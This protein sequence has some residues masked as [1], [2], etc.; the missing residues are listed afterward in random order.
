MHAIDEL[1]AKDSDPMIG[2]IQRQLRFVEEWTREGQRPEQ[3][4][5]D[6]LNFGLMASRAVD[7]TNQDLANQLYELSSYLKFW[8]PPGGWPKTEA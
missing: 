6:R 8:P 1:A 7:D 5:I 2:S 3:D 4:E